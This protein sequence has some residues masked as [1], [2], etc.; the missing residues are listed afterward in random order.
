M[1]RHILWALSLYTWLYQGYH[2]QK[3]GVREFPNREQIN[4][5]NNYRFVIKYMPLTECTC[6]KAVWQ[7]IQVCPKDSIRIDLSDG[8]R[9]KF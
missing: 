3:S 9:N 5:A 6:C 1:Q 4:R 8:A 7:K 2:K